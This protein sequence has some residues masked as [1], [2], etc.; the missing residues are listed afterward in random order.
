MSKIAI[1]MCIFSYSLSMVLATDSSAQRKRMGELT[2]EV[3]NSQKLILDLFEEIEKTHDLVFAY[4]ASDLKKSSVY[5]ENKKWALDDLLKEVSVQARVSF[6]RVNGTITVKKA[7][8]KGPLPDVRESIEVAVQVKGTVYDESKEGIPGVT[9]IEK[10]T[11]NGTTTKYDGTYELSVQEGATLI[12][13]FV[14]FASQEIAIENLTVIDVTMTEDIA[15]LEEVVV[16]GYGAVKKS[17]LTGSVASVKGDVINEFPVTSVD[18][19]LQARV[20]G[21]NVSQTSSAPGGGLSVRIRGANSINSGSEPLYVI[22]GLPIYPD[23]NAIGT[24]GNRQSG[25]ALASLNPSD[26]ESIEILKDASATSIYGSRG[27]NGVVLITT[28]RGKEG[29]TL[30]DYDGSVSFQTISNEIDRLNATEYAQYRNLLAASQGASPL[31]T[32]TEIANLGEGTDWMDAILQTGVINNH[33]LSMRGGNAKTKYAIMGNLLD[34]EGIVQ[35]SSFSRYGIRL[36]MDNELI[37]DLLSLSSSWS[38]NRTITQSQSTDR[39]GP[40]GLIITAL[41]LDPTV[42]IRDADGNYNL[43]SYDGR[44]D[45]NPVQEAEHL[46]D[47]DLANRVLGT[48]ALTLQLTE[49]LR[50]RTSLGVDMVNVNRIT[51]YGPETYLGRQRSGDL[52]NFA[53][54]S[55]NL[56]NENILSYTKTFG[57]HSFDAVAGF[58][59]QHVVN[60]F[61]SVSTRNIAGSSVDN[62]T[63]GNGTNP[64]I[65]QSGRLEN[66]L[67]SYLGRVNYTYKGKYLASVT[68]RRDGASQFGENKYETYP[69]LALGWNII[70]EPFMNTIRAFSNLKLRTSYG[71][72]GNSNIPPYQSLAA[73]EANNYVFNG[74]LVSGTIAA[75]LG[76]PGLRWEYTT[77]LNLGL[78]VGLFDARLNA[79]ID[80]FRT[81]TEDLLLDV[82]IPPSLGFTSIFKNSGTLENRGVELS[83][84]YLAVDNSTLT[85]NVAGNISFIENEIISLGESAPFFASFG[86]SHLGVFGSWVEPGNAI[87]V[88]R[89]YHMIGIWQSQDEIDANPSLPGDQPGYPRYQ[90]SDGDGNINADDYVIIGD[91]NPDFTWGFNTTV[92]VANFDLGLFLRG[93]HG[94]DVRNL[95]ASEMG[96]GVQ[97]INQVGN[98]LT[99]SWS[100]TNTGGTRPVIDATRDFA[101]SLRDSDFFIEDGS[102]IRLQNVVLGYTLPKLKGIRRARIYVSAQNLFVITDYTGFDPEVNNTGQD[103]LN[104]AD[105]YDAYPRAKTFTIGVNLGF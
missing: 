60:R 63:L 4:A 17:D 33:Q 62:I 96:D 73:L 100:P 7:P 13:S 48:T 95:Q 59:Y 10:G 46:Y 19:A 37:P 69:S 57:E 53:R 104:R 105:D 88:W 11:V 2:F 38:Y 25:N 14:G 31:F 64:Q 77:M 102:F 50:L 29:V 87:G 12:F 32:E 42:S 66:T 45:I 30:I 34:N 41:G 28:K 23:N 24:E 92:S 3:K 58:T 5:L 1:Y 101:N 85:W 68:V 52:Q 80:Y 71:A 27:S 39:Q 65:P 98:L 54:Y 8:K 103:N 83:L 90:D 16:V 70:E 78:D 49:G 51:F 15:A 93:V 43:A 81:R 76:N 9:I 91:P 82:T 89:G 20:P 18:Q 99:D 6:K 67:H 97:R 22:D 75:R 94:N 55:G 79:T 61:T 86:G 84:D 26:I 44:F 21:V 35:G 36:N 56:L 40:G 74:N 72:T 47:E